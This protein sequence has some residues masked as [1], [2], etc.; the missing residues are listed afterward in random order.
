MQKYYQKLNITPSQAPIF[1]LLNDVR[2]VRANG[3]D[4]S[5]N[6]QREY[7]WT[8]EYIDKLLLSLILNYPIGNIVVNQLREPN[9]KNAKSELVDGKQRL[10]TILD[11]VD[12]NY[13]IKSKVVEEIKGT[14]CNIIKDDKSEEII[15]LKKKKKLKFEDLPKAIQNNI[16]AYN[17]PLYT[18][19]SADSFQIREYFK[20]LQNQEKLRAGEIINSLP[21]NVFY[22]Y[23]YE[24]NYEF[25]KKINYE[26]L[27]R[28]D[29]EKIYYAI[30]GVRLNKIQLNCP[31]KQ[32]I[33]FVEKKNNISE[34][35]EEILKKYNK[36]LNYI[37]GMKDN[38]EIN[39]LNKRTLKY[40]LGLAITN[41]NYYETNTYEKVS[42]IINLSKKLAAFNTSMSDDEAFSKYFG[43]QYTS[44]K[45]DFI[46]YESQKYRDIFNISTRSS[47]YSEVK[48]ICDLIIEDY[49]FNKRFY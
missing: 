28:A 1:T 4:I 11:F 13:E 23:F 40:I 6:Y 47:S 16:N 10:R 14:I 32:I 45:N 33:D 27:K 20:V 12:G 31:D 29:F 17:I 24:I 26:H 34:E 43:I 35:E 38:I 30:I 36:N 5:P 15:K 9:E 8:S 3:L 19:Q 18:I 22:D 2:N 7:V 42:H 21:D 37:L 39:G 49:N 48:R 25:L 46:E 41:E 44:R